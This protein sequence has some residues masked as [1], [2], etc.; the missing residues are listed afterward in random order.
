M[1]EVT[2]MTQKIDGRNLR[3]TDRTAPLATRFRPEIKGWFTSRGNHA[4]WRSMKSSRPP[5]KRF[6]TRTEKGNLP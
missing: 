5:V 1:T 3:E 4:I 6:I 2:D